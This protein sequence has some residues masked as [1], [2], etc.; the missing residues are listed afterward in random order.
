MRRNPTV[1]RLYLYRSIGAHIPCSP[2]QEHGKYQQ[3]PRPLTDHTP[4]TNELSSKRRTEQ[5]NLV[6]PPG[7][8]GYCRIESFQSVGIPSALPTSRMLGESY[9]PYSHGTAQHIP[10]LPAVGLPPSRPPSLKRQ[11]STSSGPSRH[12]TNNPPNQRHP[13]HT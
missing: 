6:K 11:P 4:V 3:A 8:N 7:V 5:Y 2:G 9:R 1:D 10:S 12:N 13:K